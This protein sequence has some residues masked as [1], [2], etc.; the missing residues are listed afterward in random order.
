MSKYRIHRVSEKDKAFNELLENADYYSDGQAVYCLTDKKGRVYETADGSTPVYI[1]SYNKDVKG[2]P[3][4][5][6]RNL[7][8][9]VYFTRVV[10]NRDNINVKQFT[11]DELANKNLSKTKAKVGEVSFVRVIDMNEDNRLIWADQSEEVKN[12]FLQF[13]NFVNTWY[14]NIYNLMACVIEEKVND[15]LEHQTEYDEDAERFY[16]D[17]EEEY[18]E[19]YDDDE[20]DYDDDDEEYDEDEEEEEEEEDLEY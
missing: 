17:D 6:M 14:D 1:S 13:T 5:A 12:A 11:F 20:P 7:E 18:D 16:E 2:I 15:Y 9:Q 4:E 19:D 3:S 10:A 8:A